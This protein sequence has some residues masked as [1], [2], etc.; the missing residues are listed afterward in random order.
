[1]TNVTAVIRANRSTS[2]PAP[3]CRILGFDI[4]LVLGIASTFLSLS[5]AALKLREYLLLM[6]DV[7][8]LDNLRRAETDPLPYDL[9]AKLNIVK[10][11]SDYRWRISHPAIYLSP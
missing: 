2:T 4:Y 5:L 3:T 7:G 6:R 8:H 10:A 11:D 1:M 9:L